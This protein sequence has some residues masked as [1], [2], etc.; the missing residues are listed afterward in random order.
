MTGA[1]DVN[2]GPVGQL[3]DGKYTLFWVSG[4]PK[5]VHS[6]AFDSYDLANKAFNSKPS[7]SRTLVDGNFAIKNSKS[8]SKRNKTDLKRIK[9]HINIMKR[10]AESSAAMPDTEV[11]MQE[12]QKTEEAK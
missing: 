5:Q 2:D 9:E 8:S 1:V 10:D 4:N 12:S 7:V 11:S 6:Q 3:A